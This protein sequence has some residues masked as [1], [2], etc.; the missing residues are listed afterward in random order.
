MLKILLVDDDASQRRLFE[1]NAQLM[2]DI[3]LMAVD[4]FTAQVMNWLY[5]DLIVVDVMMPVIDGAELSRQFIE[6][7]GDSLPPI[8]LLS[9]MPQSE[10][11]K[12]AEGLPVQ[13]L[14]K[15]GNPKRILKNITSLAMV[16]AS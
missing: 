5:Y 12:F 13:C 9:A 11:Q 15:S 6:K 14:T 1:Y 4:Q 7:Y 2:E 3:R 8:V 10:L 16:Q